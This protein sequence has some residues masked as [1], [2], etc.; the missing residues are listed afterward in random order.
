M[1]NRR[2]SFMTLSEGYVGEN[3]SDFNRAALIIHARKRTNL[4]G[5]SFNIIST[6]TF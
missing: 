6:L 5:I 4:P 2:H 1:E 3:I